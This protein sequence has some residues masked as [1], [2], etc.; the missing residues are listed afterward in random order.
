MN[1][2]NEGVELEDMSRNTPVDHK[3]ALRNIKSFVLKDQYGDNYVDGIKPIEGGFR[4]EG[5]NCKNEARFID[6]FDDGKKCGYNNNPNLGIV[7]KQMYS[8]RTKIFEHFNEQLPE[9]H[10]QT[11]TMKP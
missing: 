2:E 6:I 7:E 4:V 11:K 5:R 9:A 3:H 1:D 8:N 10:R